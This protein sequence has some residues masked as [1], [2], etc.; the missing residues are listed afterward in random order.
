VTEPLLTVALVGYGYWGVN[1]ARNLKASAHIS[2]VGIVEEDPSRRAAAAEAFP[3]VGTWSSVQALLDDSPAEALVIATPAATHGD[4]ALQALERKRHV[5]IEKPM[6]LRLEVA[7]EIERVGSS[8]G[9]VVMAGHTFLYSPP[10]R[11]LYDYIVQGELGKVQYIYSQRLSL[12]RIRR[13]CSA[14]WNLAPH[15][16]SILLYLLREDPVEVSARALSFVQNEIPDV[17]FATIQ[18]ESGITANL[19]VSWLDPRKVRLMTVVGDRKMAVF[20]DVSPDQK[21][22]LY[23]AGVDQGQEHGLGEYTSMGEFQWRTRVGDV[24]I[25]RIPMVEPLQAEVEAFARA[26]QGGEDPP[27]NA[28]HGVKVV[29]T[30]AAI[31]ESARQGGAPIRISC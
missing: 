5:L 20:D 31:D 24:V 10:V 7:E 11:R 21:I 16:V 19:H 28:R 14:L 1:L 3:D 29:R 26:C 23:D 30:L 6:A 12:G 4:I 9:L 18:F 15:D 22:T 17:F 27:S 2:L 8:M 13:D 25:P